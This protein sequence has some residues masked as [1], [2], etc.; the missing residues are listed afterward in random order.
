MAN[1]FDTR[2]SCIP[3]NQSSTLVAVIEQS[4]DNWFAGGLYLDSNVTRSRN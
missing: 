1:T 4:K 2:K 3:F